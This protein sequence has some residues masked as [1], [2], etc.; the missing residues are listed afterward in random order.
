MNITVVG[1]NIKRLRTNRGINQSVLADFLGVDQS[2]IC[3][4][5][6]GSRTL[7]ADM[8]EKLAHLFGVTTASLEAENVPEETLSYAFRSNEL[9]ATDMQAICAINKIALNLEDMN[10]W[11]KE[12]TL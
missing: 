11:L 10:R 12:S 3:K 9:S 2:L 8:L 5:E 6:K 1:E 7:S 4:I